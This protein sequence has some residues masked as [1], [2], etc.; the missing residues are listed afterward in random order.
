M[1]SLLQW[2]EEQDRIKQLAHMREQEWTTHVTKLFDL[3]QEVLEPCRAY[4]QEEIRRESLEMV[5]SFPVTGL[6][7]VIEGWTREYTLRWYSLETDFQVRL[8]R[9]RGVW[10]NPNG[11][12][13]LDTLPVVGKGDIEDFFL[14]FLQAPRSEK[15]NPGK[16]Y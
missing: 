10:V 8:E 11:F 4:F 14:A 15:F 16:V 13:M 1:T 7:V 2:L 5:V 12:G 9:Q 3:I 6:T